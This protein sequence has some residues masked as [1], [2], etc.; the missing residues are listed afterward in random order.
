MG[1]KHGKIHSGI[2]VKYAGIAIWMSVGSAMQE[3]DKHKPQRQDVVGFMKCLLHAMKQYL[4]HSLLMPR[5]M[6]PLQL[7]SSNIA[8]MIDL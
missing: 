1:S 2:F 6:V 5:Q 3:D 7:K 8:D 4:C